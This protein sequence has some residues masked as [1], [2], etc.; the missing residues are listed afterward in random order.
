MPHPANNPQT[1]PP[2]NL[3]ALY[4]SR[5]WRR[6]GSTPWLTNSALA[7]LGLAL[8]WLC[9]QGV[10]EIHHFVIGFGLVAMYQAL[11]YL[12]AVW[13]VLNWPANRWTF[14]IIL[15]CAAACRLICIF[16]PPFLSTDIFRYVWDGRVQAAG[17]NPFRYI[18]AD[19]HLAFLR[20]LDIYP[21]INRRTYAHTVYPPGA[22][23]LFLLISRLG[24]SVRWMK[25]GI[26]G[27]EA[28]TI[29]VLV[30]LL[31]AIG[32]RREQVLLYAW[33]PLLL[34]EVASSGHVDGAALPLIVLALLFRLRQKPASTGLALAAATLMKLYPIALFPAL[35]RRKLDWKMP[36]CVVGVIAAGYACYLSVG[37]RVLGFL[38]DYA[39]EEGMES[40]S[41]YFLLTL[42]RHVAHWEAL[43]AAAFYGFA[44][45]LLLGL[46][47][48]A[49]WR[50][51]NS[52]LD[53]IRCS[54]VLA[55]ALMLLFSSHYPW[56]YLWLLPFVCVIPYVPMLYFTTACF[57]LYTTQLAN[58]G[59]DMYY[60]FEWLYGTTALLALWCV[61]LRWSEARLFHSCDAQD[62]AFALYSTSARNS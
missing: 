44:A 31:T 37:P 34:W 27:V 18:P 9:R 23:M 39:R 49:W 2:P 56:Y 53:A 46:A 20:D 38:P 51:E 32:L 8:V 33:H 59:P 36:A 42:V 21:N 61:G 45:L 30:K 57:Y 6:V 1:N 40:G 47:L 10:S 62:K 14:V 16:S 19:P 12:V 43:P 24:E 15:V 54:F 4:P 11:L 52:P 35:Y 41:R 26:T 3:A 50:S 60:M 7:V 17:I 55:A 5:S 28:L 22:Q 13:V 58:P 48:W 25:L 29:W